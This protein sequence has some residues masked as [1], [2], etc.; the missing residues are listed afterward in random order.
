MVLQSYSFSVNGAP[1]EVQIESVETK[2]APLEA[3]ASAAPVSVVSETPAAS[4]AASVRAA[5]AYPAQPAF[6]F[7]QPTQ[8]TWVT[9]RRVAHLPFH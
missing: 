1:C 4:S 7:M 8:A 3:G 2:K 9:A 5:Q 6:A